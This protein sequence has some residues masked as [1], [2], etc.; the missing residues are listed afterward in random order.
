MELY[1]I[2]KNGTLEIGQII[3]SGE[4]YNGY[5]GIYENGPELP[6]INDIQRLKEISTYY[7]HFFRETILEE[8]RK[9]KYPE[10]PSRQTGLFLTDV[11]SLENWLSVLGYTNYQL[12]SMKLNGKLHACDATLIDI[13]PNNKAVVRELANRYWNGEIVD[14]SKKVEYIFEGTAEV[15]KIH[16]LNYY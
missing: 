1:H 13:H 12:V 14:G 8:V 11:R 6:L 7:W 4:S 2:R 3:K 5:Y 16:T 15:T 10:Y 9:E